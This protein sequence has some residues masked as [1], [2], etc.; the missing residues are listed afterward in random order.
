M[1]RVTVQNVRYIQMAQMVLSLVLLGVGTWWIHPA[2]C[3]V[4]LGALLWVDLTIGTLR[5]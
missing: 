3:C 1:K 4:V 2:L 5:K